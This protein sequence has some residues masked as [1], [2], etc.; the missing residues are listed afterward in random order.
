MPRIEITS[1]GYL[2]DDPPPARIVC[3]LRPFRDPHWNTALRQLTARDEPVAQAVMAT[4]G[5]AA[6][7]DALAAMTRG[8]LA[9]PSPAPVTIAIGCAGG[10]HRSAQVSQALEA[11]LLADGLDVTVIHRDIDLPVVER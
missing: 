11:L 9:A 10:R 3:D 2:H 8:Y 1:F 6:V 4:S 5:I 7:V